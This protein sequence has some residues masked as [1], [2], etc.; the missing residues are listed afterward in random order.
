MV[1]ALLCERVMV[2]QDGVKTVL[3]IVDRITQTHAGHNPPALMPSFNAVLHLLIK[4][5]AGSCRG[6]H[7][8]Q[9]RLT[10]PNG[11]HLIPFTQAITLSD[12]EE[13]LGVDVVGV[14]QVRFEA[15][16]VYWF[17]TLLDGSVLARTPLRVHYER[18]A[19]TTAA[20]TSIQ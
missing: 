9:V 1:A 16:G 6:Q 10:K 7:H 3:R 8:L 19:R 4:L 2:E 14:V 17:D 18:G 13:D 15:E 20:P 12:D 5:K 11:S